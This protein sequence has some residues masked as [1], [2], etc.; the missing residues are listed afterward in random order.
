MALD[1]SALLELVEMMRSADGNDLMRRLLGTMLQALVDAEATGHIGA[2]PHERTDARTTQRN[3]T[4]DKTVTTTAGDLT[5]KTRRCGPG[6]SSRRRSRRAG[7]ST[8]RCTR[9]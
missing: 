5:V 3:G 9:W 1:Q 7:A 2:E 8:W 6:R 4:R